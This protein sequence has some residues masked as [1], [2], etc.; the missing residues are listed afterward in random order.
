MVDKK[1]IREEI[2]RKLHEEMGCL[3]CRFCEERL[4]T[5]EPCCCYSGML[6]GRDSDGRCLMRD[7]KDTPPGV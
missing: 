6:L 1:A 4:R 5:T 7:E 3:N 2:F